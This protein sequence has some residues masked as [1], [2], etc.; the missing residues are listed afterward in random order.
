MH[1]GASVAIMQVFFSAVHYAHDYFHCNYAGDYVS[2]VAMYLTVS[3]S[4]SIS[5]SL[6]DIHFS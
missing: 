2:V 1:V 4:N 5:L 3:S 6:T